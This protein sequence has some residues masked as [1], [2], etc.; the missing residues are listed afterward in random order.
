MKLFCDRL[1]N[2]AGPH[3]DLGAGLLFDNEGSTETSPPAGTP[4]PYDG[5]HGTF[6]LR[7]P[8]QL[9]ATRAITSCNFKLE[10]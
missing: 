7:S 5:P 4:I 3:E 1:A 9:P 8:D 6:D 10:L 2:H